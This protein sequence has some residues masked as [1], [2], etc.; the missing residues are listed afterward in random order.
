MVDFHQFQTPAPSEFLG[1]LA[2]AASEAWWLPA[3][4]YIKNRLTAGQGIL[5]SVCR[6]KSLHRKHLRKIAQSGAVSHP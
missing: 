1:Q 4:R 2:A 3:E 5:A 6:R